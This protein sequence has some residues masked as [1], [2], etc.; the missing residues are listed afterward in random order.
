MTWSCKLCDKTFY[1]LTMEVIFKNNHNGILKTTFFQRKLCINSVKPDINIQHWL[2]AGRSL[3]NNTLEKY[4]HKYNTCTIVLTKVDLKIRLLNYCVEPKTKTIR[5]SA[6]HRQALLSL[7]KKRFERKHYELRQYF[8]CIM[9]LKH[10][11]QTTI[12]LIRNC[13]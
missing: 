3:T 12:V 6:Q 1:F 11:I 10:P 4:I 5:L 7:P 13:N 2:K 8:I 9:S